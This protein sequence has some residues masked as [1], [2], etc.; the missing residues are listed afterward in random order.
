[1]NFM[2]MSISLLQGPA[3]AGIATQMKPA[4]INKAEIFIIVL[5][6]RACL[7]VRNE[8]TAQAMSHSSSKQ[9]PKS[10]ASW[11]AISGAGESPL[12][13]GP[14]VRMARRYFAH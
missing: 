2:T 3:C 12:D 5:H 10:K 11:K 13:L 14:M 9:G 4:A 7:R 1:M 8:R 6:G